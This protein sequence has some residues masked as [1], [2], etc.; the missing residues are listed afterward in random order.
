M[1]KRIISLLL[2]LFAIFNVIFPVVSFGTD[3]KEAL[4]IENKV[5]SNIKNYKKQSSQSNE[6]DPSKY[7]EE[8]KRWLELPEEE[9][10]RWEVIP[11]KY[12]VPI[13]EIYNIDEKQ[14]NENANVLKRSNIAKSIVEQIPEKYD[15]KR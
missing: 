7:T 15:F 9:R 13:S 8:Y 12:V 6:E 1:K 5:T 11:R 2:I 3:E 10:N 4:S 14:N